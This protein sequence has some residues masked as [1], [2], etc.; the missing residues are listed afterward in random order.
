MKFV[1]FDLGGVVVEIRRTWAEVCQGAGLAWP[2]DAPD[3]EAPIMSLYER[4]HADEFSVME[5]A[6]QLSD[7]TGGRFNAAQC[8]EAHRAILIGE[9]PGIFE[10]ITKLHQQNQKTAILS[11]TC[12]DHWAILNRYPS[13][14][15]VP[16]HF[17]SFQMKVSKPSSGIYQAVKSELGVAAEEL[18][19]F[20]DSMANIKAAKQCGWNGEWIDPT[21]DPGVQIRNYLANYK[22]L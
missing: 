18:L 12:A 11:N 22:I 3:L 2:S 8:L 19:F 16:L 17:T 4:Y 20:D 14:E 7:L 1:V 6:N 21:Q 10:I 15:A 5:L 9:Y 13:I